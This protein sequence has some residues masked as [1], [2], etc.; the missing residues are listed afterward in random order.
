MNTSSYKSLPLLLSPEHPC[1][2]LQGKTAR[3]AFL[4]AQIGTHDTAYSELLAQGFRRS[5]AY[6][7]RPDCGHCRACVPLRVAVREFRPDRS[8]QRTWRRNQDLDVC[9]REAAFVP[10]HF[11][12]YC[13]YLAWKHPGGGMDKPSP[14]DYASFLLSP[15]CTLFVEIR[16]HEQLLA[17]AAVDAMDTAWSAV[18]TFYAPEARQRSLGTF[19]VLWEISEARQRGLEWLYLG[20]WISAS[21][22]MAYK[23]RF[24]PHECLMDSRWQRVTRSDV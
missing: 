24:L 14:A 16:L 10:E 21:P 4:D 6:F 17:V 12:L 3:T 8:Q 5:G 7:Y 13:R 20:Y 18:Y 11:D 9:M 1:S 2:Y 23:Q 19:A 15:R 22:K